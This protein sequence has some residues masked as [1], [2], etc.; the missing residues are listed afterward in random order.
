MTTDLRFYRG[1][2]SPQ[3]KW[4][5][6]EVLLPIPIELAKVCWSTLSICRNSSNWLLW[7]LPQSLFPLFYCVGQ[8]WPICGNLMTIWVVEPQGRDGKPARCW[9][10]RRAVWQATALIY[11]EVPAPTNP[12]LTDS[13]QLLMVELIYESMTNVQIRTQINSYQAARFTKN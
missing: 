3:I 2:P 13:V 6:V 1:I 7:L 10:W 8:S 9:T 4:K 12:S 5:Q 11:T